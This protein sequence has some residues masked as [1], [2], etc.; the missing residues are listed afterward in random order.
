MSHPFRAAVE[1]RDREAMLATLAPTVL[2]HSPVAFKPFAGRDAVGQVLE[3]VSGAF[4]DFRYTDELESDG[5]HALIFRARAGDRAIPGRDL[6][7]AD[8]EGRLPEL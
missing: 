5:L 4:E 3:A 6:L 1:A 8:D 7:R 2:F